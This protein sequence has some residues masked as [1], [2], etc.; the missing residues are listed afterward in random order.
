V[1]I[2]GDR[3]ADAAAAVTI[4]SS[5]QTRSAFLGAPRSVSYVVPIPRALDEDEWTRLVVELR[6]T[7]GAVGKVRTEGA[8]RSWTNGNL[9]IHVEPHADAYRV[10]MRTLRGDLVPRL[11]VGA[12][13]TVVAGI[14]LLL[15]L[16]GEATA[17]QSIMSVVFGV[18]GLGTLTHARWMLGAWAEE[19]ASQFEGLAERIPLLL[20]E[21]E[22]EE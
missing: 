19:R 20:G 12:F 4:R 10:R 18:S 2:D 17:A 14:L 15:T 22:A 21:P 5:Q 11:T 7:F 1:G 13:F 9:Q 3:I 6:E 16:L 8:L